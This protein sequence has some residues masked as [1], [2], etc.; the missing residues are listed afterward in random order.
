MKLVIRGI[1]KAWLSELVLAKTVVSIFALVCQ[2][3]VIFERKMWSRNRGVARG[4]TLKLMRS[5]VKA[6]VCSAL[7]SGAKLRERELFCS[8]ATGLYHK[9]TKLNVLTCI[10]TEFN[11]KIV[12]LYVL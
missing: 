1:V 6:C 2:K 7:L 5:A 11:G 8:S 10:L 9:V 12:V 4:E 3:R